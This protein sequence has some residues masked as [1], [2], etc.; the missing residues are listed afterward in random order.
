MD[1]RPGK[2]VPTL[3]DACAK[4][5]F[6]LNQRERRRK[7]DHGRQ[8]HSVTVIEVPVATRHFPVLDSVDFTIRQAAG[9]TVRG[10]PVSTVSY[11]YPLYDTAICGVC[12]QVVQNGGHKVG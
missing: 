1:L 2:V 8:C 9:A 4:S 7:P 5:R 3:W 6:F 12:A 11:P 10:Y